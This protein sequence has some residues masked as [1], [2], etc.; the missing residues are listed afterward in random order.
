MNDLQTRLLDSL[1]PR[2]PRESR[3]AALRALK[4]WTLVDCD[5]AVVMVKGAEV[6]VAAPQ[7]VRGKWLSRRHIREVLGTRL[8]SFGL[9]KTSVALDNE[10]GQRFVSRLGFV[11]VERDAKAIRYELKELRHA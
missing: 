3:D 7:A 10:A 6:H 4:D 5:G 8:R 1:G 9:V 11:E 2:I